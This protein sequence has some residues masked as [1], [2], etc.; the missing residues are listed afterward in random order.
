MEVGEKRQQFIKRAN[1]AIKDNEYDE[2]LEK[3]NIKDIDNINKWTDAEYNALIDKI[4]EIIKDGATA[5]NDLKTVT[6]EENMPPLY[7]RMRYGII[8][9]IFGKTTES[10]R[11]K[12]FG[13]GWNFKRRFFCIR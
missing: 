12:S 4:N 13:K 6:E 10:S 1:D 9:S 7:D 2:F 11:V 3:E 5:K 8:A